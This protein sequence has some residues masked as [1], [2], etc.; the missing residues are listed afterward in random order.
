MSRGGGKGAGEEEEGFGRRE[1]SWE[2]GK[3]GGR[4]F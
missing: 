2:E 4:G 1:R 3:G